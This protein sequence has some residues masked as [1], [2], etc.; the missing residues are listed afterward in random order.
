MAPD[1]APQADLRVRRARHTSCYWDDRGPNLMSRSGARLRASSVHLAVLGACGQWRTPTE[2]SEMLSK[3]GFEVQ[4]AIE[5][6]TGAGLLQRNDGPRS[7]SD[8][9]DEWH[10]WLPSASIFHQGTRRVRWR[11][12][13]EWDQKVFTR[14]PEPSKLKGTEGRRSFELPG[15]HEPTALGRVLRERR[16]WRRFRPGPIRLDQLGTL[17]Q[18]TWGIQCWVEINGVSPQALKS[19]PSAGARHSIEAYVAA[20]DV[21]GLPPGLYHY[22]ADSHRLAEIRVGLERE[23]MSRHLGGQEMFSKC[24]FVVFLSSVFERVRWKYPHPS[25]YAVIL[26]ECGHLGQSFLLAATELGLAP[27]STAAVD[28]DSV[29]TALGLD[30]ASEAVLYA[31]GVGL[32][33]PEPW[34]PFDGMEGTVK[35]LARDVGMQA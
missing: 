17:L 23:E 16:T 10:S 26:M 3:P 18:V 2:I 30:G 25:G 6:L 5:E 32:R 22:Q 8:P 35:Y 9:L 14:T 13:L 31:V 11:P 27:F 1:P 15:D 29:E 12:P 21:E 28:H 34:T 20:I 7:P 33:P 24:G 4:A 19:S